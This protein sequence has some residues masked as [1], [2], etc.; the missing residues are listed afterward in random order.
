MITILPPLPAAA[1]FFALEQ[2]L[3]SL[4][5]VATTGLGTIWSGGGSA[6]NWG[7]VCLVYGEC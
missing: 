6:L 1:A 5:A 3:A 2:G 4:Q 7:R